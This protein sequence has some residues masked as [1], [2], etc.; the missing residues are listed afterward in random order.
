MKIENLDKKCL[1][2]SLLAQ[3]HPCEKDHP[4][5]VQNYGQYFNE[6]NIE[7]FNFTDG[8]KCSDFQK[9]E[10]LNSLSTNMFQLII[11]QDQ[12]K[13]KHKLIS[14]EISKKNEIELLTY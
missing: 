13:W 12:N 10:K 14:I 6:L 2:W 1:L 5:G 3:L 4:N 8:I 7:G 9:F 11:Y